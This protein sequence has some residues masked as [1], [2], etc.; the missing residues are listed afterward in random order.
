MDSRE[1]IDVEVEMSE[2]LREGY[3]RLRLEV[4]VLAHE[5]M[6]RAQGVAYERG[7]DE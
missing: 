2:C 4:Q 6:E 5:L 3:G 1:L 7:S